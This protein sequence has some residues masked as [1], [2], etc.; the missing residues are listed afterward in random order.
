[1]TDFTAHTDTTYE[2][3]VATAD[4]EPVYRYRSELIPSVARNWASAWNQ[5]KPAD[6]T[7]SGATFVAVRATTTYEKVTW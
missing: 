2:V 7:L 3:W 4:G 6:V 1:M 5:S